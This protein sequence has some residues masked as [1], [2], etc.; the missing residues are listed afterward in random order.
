MIEWAF[1]HPWMTFFIICFLI[2]AINNI[3]CTLFGHSDNSSL[4]HTINE[5]QEDKK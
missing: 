3:F 4:V 1:E 5:H 2:Q